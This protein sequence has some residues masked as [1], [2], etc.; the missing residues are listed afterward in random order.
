MYTIESKELAELSERMANVDTRTK[1][2]INDGLRA[3][4]RLFV[5]VKGT[6][7]LADETPVRTGKLRRSTYFQV[8]RHGNEQRVEIRQPAR[9]PAGDYYGFWVREGTEPHD[10]YPVNK[11]ALRF[12]IGGNIIFAKHVHHP[13][14]RANP[15]HRRVFRRLLPE[16]N[17]I[18][19]KMGEAVTA[20][21]SGKGA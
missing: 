8:M 18:I 11:T 7:P 10:I 5:P 14:S 4:G 20:Y 6:G 13:G 16:V 9:T 3:L 19:V 15:Y 17:A 12:E 2:S 1:I 21:I